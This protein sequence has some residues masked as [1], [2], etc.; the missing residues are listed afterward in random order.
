MKSKA[1]GFSPAE[2]LYGFEL[3]MPTSWAPPIEE[4]ALEESIIERVRSLNTE[5]QNIRATGV[6]KMIKNKNK[7]KN[8]YNQG[9]KLSTFEVGDRVLKLVEQVKSK[10]EE[11]CEGPYIIK[12]EE[13]NKDLV[14]GDRLKE[15]KSSRYC[16]RV[17]K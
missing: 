4:C 3:T 9:V 8:Q 12:Y 16:C 7:E 10:L 5:L 13:N 11:K 17:W 15:F 6:S 14:H 1:T 2:M